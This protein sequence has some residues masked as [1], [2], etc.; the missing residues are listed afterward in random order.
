[1][2]VLARKAEAEAQA[3]KA[4]LAELVVLLFW[5]I[6]GWVLMEL[7]SKYGFDPEVA[8]MLITNG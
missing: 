4:E 7:I 3:A 8:A 1:V 6:L 2:L 5:F